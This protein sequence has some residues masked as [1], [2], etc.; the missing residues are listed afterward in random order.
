MS[1]PN[2]EPESTLV[3]LMLPAQN[4][5]LTIP[6]EFPQSWHSVP[7]LCANEP[8]ALLLGTDFQFIMGEETWKLI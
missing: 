4:T 7:L 8:T 5:D 2:P 3:H 6:L 1:D